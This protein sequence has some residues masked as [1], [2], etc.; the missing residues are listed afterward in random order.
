MTTNH[1]EATEKVKL[2]FLLCSISSTWSW[3]AIALA[4]T[5]G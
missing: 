1:L 4:T 2:Q 3:S 5:A